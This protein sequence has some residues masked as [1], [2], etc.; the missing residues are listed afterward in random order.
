MRYHS[1]YLFKNTIWNDIAF[2]KLIDYCLML[3]EL[4]NLRNTFGNISWG[5]QLPTIFFFPKNGYCW[6]VFGRFPYIEH[7]YFPSLC[8]FKKTHPSLFLFK[9]NL[10]L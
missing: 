4:P 2:K 5:K 1:K 10:C 7:E 8:S 3:L 6:H 9:T